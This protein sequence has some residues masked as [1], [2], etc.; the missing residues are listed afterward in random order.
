MDYLV[1]AGSLATIIWFSVLSAMAML[2]KFEL[3]KSSKWDRVT[4]AALCV[5][6]AIGSVKPLAE[7]LH[8]IIGGN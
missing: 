1:A 4:L 6:I 7:T 2:G 8:N 5:Y 3:T